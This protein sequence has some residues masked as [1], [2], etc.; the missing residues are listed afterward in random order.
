MKEDYA[1][2]KMF[3]TKVFFISFSCHNCIVP[4][5]QHCFG[6]W[7]RC[8]SL[9]TVNVVIKSDDLTLYF[10]KIHIEKTDRTTGRK[11]SIFRLKVY[12]Y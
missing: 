4:L 1:K 10:I 3:C 5:G 6:D 8:I 9:A 12:A 7:P 11:R 2:S